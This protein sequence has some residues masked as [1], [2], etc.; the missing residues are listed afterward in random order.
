MQPHS[1][2]RRSAPAVRSLGDV[3][4]PAVRA[5]LD[6]A[7]ARPET[8][9][10]LLVGSRAAGW[11]EPDGDYD[12]FILVTPEAHRA[13][14][15]EQAQ[16]FLFAEGSYPRRLIGDFT[17]FSEESLEEHL[18]SPHDIDHWPYVDAAVLADR[19]GR[20]PDW[21]RRLRTLPDGER[22]ERAIHKYI[23]LQIACHYATA[24][25]VRGFEVDR[26]MNLYRAAL[27]GV[28]LWFTLQGRWSPPFK[29]WTREIERLEM[30]PDTRGILEGSIRNPTIETA[31]LLRDHLKSEMRHAGITEVDDFVRAFIERLQPAHREARYRYSYL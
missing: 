7:L 16:V 19:T 27:A 5:Y 12:F 3:T 29:W 10:L 15:P 14:S 4:E 8:L 20:L 1:P 24:D 17:Y 6:E 23:Q 28:H 31:T 2:S 21:C 18:A 11:A 9:G 26:Q 30:R 13:L 22:K 25:D